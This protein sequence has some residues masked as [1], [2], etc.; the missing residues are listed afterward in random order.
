[1]TPN[2][3]SKEQLESSDV[4][5]YIGPLPSDS[6]TGGFSYGLPAKAK[7]TL[8]SDFVSIGDEKWEGVHFVPITKKLV[9]RLRLNPSGL[10]QA[11]P[12]TSVTA[13]ISFSEGLLGQ[14]NISIGCN[15]HRFASR[16]LEVAQRPS[17]ATSFLE[18]FRM[19]LSG[20]RLYHC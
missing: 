10:A 3:K 11:K 15:K 17:R 9:A 8:H 18:V 6:A 14:S 4:I 7:I 5:L 1:M 19:L 13:F 12:Y 2:T 20:R 16:I